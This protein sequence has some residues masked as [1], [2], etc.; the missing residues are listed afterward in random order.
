MPEEAQ[1]NDNVFLLF[2]MPIASIGYHRQFLEE[3]LHSMSN[4]RSSIFMLETMPLQDCVT[5]KYPWNSTV[6]TPDFTGIPADIL[7]IA[8]FESVMQKM[9]EMEA[10]L[11]ARLEDT[12][13]RELDGRKVGGTPS[14]NSHM[15]DITNMWKSVIKM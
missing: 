13:R 4:L 2:K 11:S 10:K 3:N 12:L 5:V 9:E 6:D 8:K 1:S 7:I 15:A 14:N